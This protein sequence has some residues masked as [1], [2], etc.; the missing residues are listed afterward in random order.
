MALFDFFRKPAPEAPPPAFDPLQDLV[1]EKLQVGFLVDYDL[2]TWKV[3]AYNRYEFG[4]GETEVEEWEITAGRD[5]RYLE[6]I[7][8]DGAHWSLSQKIPIGALGKARNYILEH[9]DA[10]AE[11]VYQGLNFYQ[12][13][14]TAGYFFPGGKVTRQELILWDYQSA[15]EASFVTIEQWSET[16]FDATWGKS[17]EAYE[18]SNILPGA[19]EA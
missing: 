2:K 15:D 11:V 8:Q 4:G 10:P 14:S 7:H 13:V 19:P 18:F 12:D 5:Q 9:D 1:L 3:T 6:V 17:V 16:E